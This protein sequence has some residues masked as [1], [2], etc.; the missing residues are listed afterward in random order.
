MYADSLVAYVHTFDSDYLHCMAWEA[1]QVCPVARIDKLHSHSVVCTVQYQWCA[2][3]HGVH[4]MAC[5]S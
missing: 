5:T 3:F 1:T 2:R 4:F